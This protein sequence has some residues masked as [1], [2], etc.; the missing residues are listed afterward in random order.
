MLHA[1]VTPQTPQRGQGEVLPPRREKEAMDHSKRMD[2][3]NTSTTKKFVNTN[4]NKT[5]Q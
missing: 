4:T 1:Y 2:V 5:K 3:T